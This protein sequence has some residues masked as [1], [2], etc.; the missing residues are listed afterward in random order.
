MVNPID[1]SSDAFF[2]LILRQSYTDGKMNSFIR[3]RRKILPFEFLSDSFRGNSA[4]FLCRHGQNNR[5][6]LS[7]IAISGISL[8]QASFYH[9]TESEQNLVSFNMTVRIVEHLEIVEIKKQKRQGII[10]AFD[11]VQFHLKLII[12]MVLMLLIRV[13]D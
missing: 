5:K 7:A 2:L 9:L 3:H 12:K 10:M 8:A 1:K 11:P 13:D 4:L 6:F